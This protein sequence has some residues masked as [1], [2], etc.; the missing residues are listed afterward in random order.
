MAKVWRKRKA[1]ASIPGRCRR[2]PSTRAVAGV[3]VL[4]ADALECGVCCL[5][6][7]P[8]IFQCQV[9]HVVCFRCRYKLWLTGAG[10]CHVC[11]V[12]VA[13]YRRCRAM[14]RLVA[15]IRV[16][17]PHA[18]HGCTFLP[19]YHDLDAHRLVCR[20][21]PCHCPG[22][23]CGFVG[24]AA[25]LLDHFAA[26]HNWPCTTNVRAGEMVSAHLRDGFTFLRVH[27]HRR[28]SAT[29]SDHLIMLNVTREP[30]GRAIS[31]LCIRPHAAEQ[32]AMQCELLFVSRFGY[33]GDGDMCRSHY[34]KS[35]FHIGCTDL[36]DGLP[37][38]K[39]C[40]Q[41]VVPWCVLEDDDQGGIQIKVR[42][43]IN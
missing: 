24:S 6:L 15:S 21:A 41:F 5:P 2:P 27:H 36:A 35:E 17:C 42:I 43:T 7:S 16:A 10:K 29:F 12:A 26:A 23:A 33:N 18:A 14:E 3:T 34:Q 30:L 22:D 9:G 31:V 1:P 11:G 40:F 28:G 19:A 4:E 39:Q 38:R 20:H 13:A 32:P 37:D 8:P 25:A